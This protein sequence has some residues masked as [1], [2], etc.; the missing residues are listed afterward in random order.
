ME[1]SSKSPKQKICERTRNAGT[2][3]NS[4]GIMIEVANGPPKPFGLAKISTNVTQDTG[5]A[6]SFFSGHLHL[7]VSIFYKLIKLSR[8]LDYLRGLESSNLFV[9]IK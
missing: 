9:F 8:S 4:F 5:L 1:A 6:I 7:T 3:K 2:S